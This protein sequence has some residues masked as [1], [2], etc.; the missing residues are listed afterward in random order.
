MTPQ[1]E[2]LAMQAY[3]RQRLAAQ[4]RLNLTPGQQPIADPNAMLQR[5]PV[6][7]GVGSASP[8]DQL[9]LPGAE[10]TGDYATGPRM[11]A[12]P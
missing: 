8:P 9:Q 10:L 4:G 3:V 1:E 5:L 12:Q 11:G 2:Q 7:P 6:A